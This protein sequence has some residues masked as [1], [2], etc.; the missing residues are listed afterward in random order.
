MSVLVDNIAELPFLCEWGLSILIE[1]DGTK[2]LLDTGSSDMFAK[3]A[4]QLAINLSDVNLGVLSHAHC[5]HSD[6]IDTFFSLNETAPFLIR[7][8]SRE[9][10]F[11][12]KEGA[13]SALDPLTAIL[14]QNGVRFP[15]TPCATEC[16]S[17][18]FSPG[19]N[20]HSKLE[21]THNFGASKAQNSCTEKKPRAR[22]API[23]GPSELSLFAEETILNPRHCHDVHAARPTHPRIQRRVLI[24]SSLI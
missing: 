21:K 22:K 20:R 3:N 11:G 17:P 5:D 16:I 1:A 19:G 9:N 6:G 2:I 15:P 7:E 23:Y 10:C 24:E 4:E 18:D 13:M 12:L 14:R 8:G